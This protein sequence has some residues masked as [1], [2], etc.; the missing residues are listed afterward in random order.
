MRLKGTWE[1]GSFKS[2]KWILENNDFFEGEFFNNFP[3]GK[4]KWV[5]NDG[6]VVRGQY[7]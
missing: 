6:K 5:K 3:K 2:G 7:T 1:E 4:G